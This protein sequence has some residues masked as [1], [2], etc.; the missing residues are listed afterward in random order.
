MMKSSAPARKY[1]SIT[2]LAPHLAVKLRILPRALDCR[3]TEII[4]CKGSPI[5][6][7]SM[8]V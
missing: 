6:A 8:S 5:A 3:V 2:W 1:T 7:G 4:A